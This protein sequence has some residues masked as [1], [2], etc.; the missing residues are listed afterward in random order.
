MSRIS[1]FWRK[2]EVFPPTIVRLLAADRSPGKVIALTDNQIA[3]RSGLSVSRVQQI[4]WSTSW[5]SITCEELKLF[6]KACNV[7]FGDPEVMKVMSKR[8]GGK[9][10]F[11]WKH[12]RE[13][14]NYKQFE[15]LII[16]ALKEYA[17]KEYALKNY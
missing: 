13:S 8:M 16:Y 17:L 6:V 10:P 14:P 15:Q 11:K 12:L 9:T 4:Y 5:D 1:G 2:L 3:E 7:D